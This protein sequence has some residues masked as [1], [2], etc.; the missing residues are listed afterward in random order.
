MA[1]AETILMPILSVLSN[2]NVVIALI[3]IV[4]FT[5]YWYASGPRNC[6]PGPLG[7]PIVGYL[8]FIGVRP[9]EKFQELAKRYGPVFR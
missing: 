5:V 6:P 3:T 2:T 8:P 9:H 1:L 7:L 4:T